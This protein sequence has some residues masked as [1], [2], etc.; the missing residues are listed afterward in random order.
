MSGFGWGNSGFGFGQMSR[1]VYKKMLSLLQ[2]TVTRASSR[3]VMGYEADGVP[4]GDELTV[5]GGFDT[6]SAWTFNDVG[7]SIVDGYLIIPNGYYNFC[8]QQ[9][10]ELEEGMTYLATVNLSNI[11]AWNGELL[12]VR[13]GGGDYTEFTEIEGVQT[14]LVVAGATTEILIGSA[15]GNA[16]CHVLDFSL[17]QVIPQTL[18]T[19][20]DNTPALEGGRLLTTV[21]EGAVLGEELCT[22]TD[23]SWWDTHNGATLADVATQT[24]DISY[25]GSYASILKHADLTNIGS[26][27]SISITVSNYVTGGLSILLG[28]G[29]TVGLD[30]NANGIYEAEDTNDGT[31]GRF[32]FGG[33]SFIG[34]LTISIREVIPTWSL[35]DAD[36]VILPDVSL[37][38]ED[39]ATNLITDSEDF[40]NPLWLKNLDAIS[41]YSD[42]G[43]SGLLNASKITL[44]SGGYMRFYVPVPDGNVATASMW[45]KSAGATNVRLTTNNTVAWDT[46]GSVKASLTS[47]WERIDV[48]WTQSGTNAYFM[49]CAIDESG[50]NDTDCYGDVLI[51]G[52]Q[53]ELGS[54]ATSYI[55]TSGGTSSRAADIATY[56]TPSVLSS[57]SGAIELTGMPSDITPY[58]VLLSSYD[59]ASNNIMVRVGAAS[60]RIEFRKEVGGASSTAFYTRTVVLDEEIKIQIYWVG[61]TYKI[62]YCASVDDINLLTFGS[63]STPSGDVKLGDFI[64]IGNEEGAAFL[65]ANYSQITCWS[66]AEKAG[67]V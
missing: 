66:S 16:P 58:K 65:P 52:A 42:I 57:E 61:D 8:L 6:N 30:L 44:S 34:T 29:N 67:W 13:V 43:P 19:V 1:H 32:Q 9:T 4:Y 10:I 12:S 50:A 46:G 48:V 14:V 56:P 39:S 55:P 27:Y 33:S 7:F 62:R 51:T 3:T 37:S 21:A 17:K 18:L 2:A 54:T 63:N 40:S 38:V 5:N 35:T 47:G 15:A 24:Y 23:I 41:V 20:P 28:N 60:S 26:R 22:A 49:I 53:L 45:V 64:S 36:G 11:G 25:S 31:D 59:D